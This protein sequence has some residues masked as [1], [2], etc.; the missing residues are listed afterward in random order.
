MKKVLQLLSLIIVAF[1]IH[2]CRDSDPATVYGWD[3]PEDISGPRIIKRVHSDNKTLESYQL[4]GS[5]LFKVERFVYDGSATEENQTV[6]VFYL[7]NRI[8]KIEVTGTYAGSAVGG[9]HVLTPNY[10]NATGTMVSLM[11][12]FY[13]SGS[14]HTFH[15]IS[16][17]QYDAE[18]RIIQSFKKTAP[19]NPATPNVYVYGNT[20]MNLITHDGPNVTKIQSSDNIVNPTTGVVQSS[21]QHTYTYDNYDWR[22]NPYK[23]VSDNYLIMMSSLFPQM[24]SYMSDNNPAKLT[25]KKDADPA[26]VTQYQYKFDTHNYPTTDGFRNFSYQP[27]P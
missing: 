24:Y 2:S 17:F 6:Y 10:D 4:N 12:D 18:G 8:S 19:V 21:V 20:V 13:A 1:V 15:S 14:V 26:V 5:S 3:N 16:V 27:A 22:N 9:R 25:V 7:G 23:R 11:D